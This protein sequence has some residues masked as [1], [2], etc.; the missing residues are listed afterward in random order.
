M[1]HT[2]TCLILAEAISHGVT[3]V[4]SQIVI[5]DGEAVQRCLGTIKNGLEPIQ[6]CHCKTV[7][8]V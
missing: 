5:A 4:I 6:R 2:P 3:F 1:D 7:T 8:H